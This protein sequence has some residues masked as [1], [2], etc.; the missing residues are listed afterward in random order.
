MKPSH[1]N[2]QTNIVKEINMPSA[3]PGSL[4]APLKRKIINQNIKASGGNAKV[5]KAMTNEA[6]ASANATSKV[7]T[8]MRKSGELAKNAARVAREAAALDALSSPS[9]R[10]MPTKK[11]VPIRSNAGISGTGGANVG[12]VF[13]PMGGGGLGGLLGSIKNR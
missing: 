2:G 11:V 7:I 9:R 5:I 13:K 12:K 4:F 10:T 3:R 8:D 1:P 6:R